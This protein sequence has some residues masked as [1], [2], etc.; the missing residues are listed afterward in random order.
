MTS[1][2]TCGRSVDPLRAPAVGVRDGKV[3]SYCS[4]ECAER[5]TLPPPQADDA[6]LASQRTDVVDAPLAMAAGVAEPVTLIESEVAAKRGALHPSE[7]TSAAAHMTSRELPVSIAPEI[8]LP[9]TA[10]T[11]DAT[12]RGGRTVRIAVV[13]AALALGGGVAGHQLGFLSISRGGG[14]SQLAA[15]RLDAVTV[16]DASHDANSLTA[17]AA[18]EQ[19]RNALMAALTSPSARVQ[20]IA[21]AALA[22]TGAPEALAALDAALANETSDLAKLEAHYVL[23][24]GGDSRGLDGLVAG[25]SVGRRDVRLEAARRLALLGDNRAINTLAQYLE[26]SQLRLGAAEQLAFLSEPRAVRVLEAVQADSKSSFD[27]KARA[28]IAL[29]HAGKS[30]VAPQL[31]SLLVDARFNAFAA[32]SLAHLR[33]APTDAVRSVLVSQLAIASLRVA[34]ARALRTLDPNLDPLPLL[35]P[36]VDALARATDTEQVTAAEAVLLLAGPPAWAQRE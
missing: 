4:H 13:T 31:R 7:L 23:A 1:C 14:V 5:T 36:L 6:A 33:A 29:G 18:V 26:V 17:A 3:V 21:A 22:R 25:L 2:P 30:E 11:G 12:A 34:A 35:R 10:G 32:A 27:D 24:R 20:R 28:A 9:T 8:N 19:A 16:A 15:P